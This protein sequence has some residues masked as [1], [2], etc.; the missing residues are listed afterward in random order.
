MSGLK[1]R[2]FHDC[3]K[4]HIEDAAA[5]HRWICECGSEWA[6]TPSWITYERTSR[7]HW[8]SRGTVSSEPVVPAGGYWFAVRRTSTWQDVPV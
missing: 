1:K 8:W 2:V 6:W 5:E 3:D 7:E 4:P